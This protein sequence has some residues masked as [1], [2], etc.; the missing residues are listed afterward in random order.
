MKI[1]YDLETQDPDDVM[2]LVILATHPLADL[3]GVTCTPG[4]TDQV[5]LIRHALR[6]VGRGGIPVGGNPER[7]KPSVSRFHETWLG[8]YEPSDPDGLPADLLRSSAEAG[9]ILLTGGPL[10]NM[11]PIPSFCE[12]VGQGGFA[13]DS[14]VPPEHRLPKF[15]GKEVCPTYNFGGAPKMAEAMLMTPRISKKTLVGKNVCHGVVWTKDFHKRVEAIPEP[16]DGLSLVIEGMTIYLRNH[17]DGKKLHDLLALTV[18][19]DEA[20]CTYES[21]ELY[22]NRSAWGSRKKPDSDVRIA[23]SVN[24][25]RF[26]QTLTRA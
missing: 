19:I 15:S 22:H 6:L 3:V 1:H 17:G 24:H 26:F 7:T 9:A 10:K 2:T 5:G 11:A 4:G 14:V 18:A 12:W 23:V 13:G 8:S 21:V 20:V 16:T 25:D